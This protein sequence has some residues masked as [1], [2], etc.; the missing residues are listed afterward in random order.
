MTEVPS[1]L[2]GLKLILSPETERSSNEIL[3]Y[4]YQNVAQELL[5]NTPHR[6]PIIIVLQVH[7]EGRHVLPTLQ[8]KAVYLD[9]HRLCT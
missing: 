3:S 4:A 8:A 6:M 7:L 2:T 9:R 1:D 5:L